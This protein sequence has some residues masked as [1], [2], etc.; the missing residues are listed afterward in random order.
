MTP[1]SRVDWSSRI[2]GGSRS[3][4]GGRGRQTDR[5]RRA[6][7]SSFGI[8]GTNA[9]VILEQPPVLPRSPTIRR[10]TEHGRLQASRR[11]RPGRCRRARRRRWRAQAG[12]VGRSVRRRS[13]A[14][15]RPWDDLAWSLVT[16][17]RRYC[18]SRAVVVGHRRRRRSCVAGLQA[19]AHGD[20]VSPPGP[21]VVTGSAVDARVAA[22][23][24]VLGS[25]LAAGRDGPGVV[26]GVPGVR[27]RVRCGVRTGWTGGWNGRCGRWCSTPTP[28]WRRRGGRSRGCSRSRWRCSGLIES[29]GITPER[30]GRPLHR[31]VG[32]RPRG[33]GAGPS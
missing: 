15:R 6:A 5:P 31:G 2:G 17:S 19:L 25:G 18:R 32:R 12:R 33:R 28:I 11:A 24:G 23:R 20:T 3:Q 29:W 7:V 13:R 10:P 30:A 21:T 22:D 27:D 14:R 16:D 9:H 4:N 8:S 26:C 1:S